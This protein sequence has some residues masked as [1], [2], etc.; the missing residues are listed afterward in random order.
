MAAARANLRGE[1]ANL[2]GQL[3]FYGYSVSHNPVRAGEVFKSELYWEPKTRLNSDYHIAVSL[4]D[5]AGHLWGQGDAVPFRGLHPMS[6][7][8]PGIVMRERHELKVNPGTPPGVYHL[9]LRVYDPATGEAL[10]GDTGD[11]SVS[12]GDIEVVRPDIPPS[13]REVRPQVVRDVSFGRRLRLLG[14]DLATRVR[15]P[16]DEIPLSTYWQA[17]GT[18]DQ[19]YRLWLRLVGADGRL[20]AEKT[21]SPT[22]ASYP[23]SRWRAWDVLQG[24]HRL[25][26]PADAPSGQATVVLSVVDAQGRPLTAHRLRWLPLGGTDIRLA[27]IEIAPRDNVVTAVPPMQRTLEARLSD[28]IELLGY[29]LKSIADPPGDVADVEIR[30]SQFV[31]Q[32]SEF[33]IELYWRTQTVVDG[34]F[35]VTVQVLSSDN[36]VIAQHDSVPAN[37]ERPTAGWLP[38]EVIADSHTLTLRPET[39]AGTYRL[40]VAMYDPTNFSRLPVSQGG[41]M[42][43]HVVL[44]TLVVR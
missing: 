24:Q 6:T 3:A 26:V 1:K 36:Q 20:L 13:P 22:S 23:T 43:D 2:G 38:G 39:P 29:N 37:W 7:W 5:D 9:A 25:I 16:G 15:R 18:L 4:T 8:E 14:F 11:P 19:D 30:D 34:N 41:E 42:R 17:L 35:K 12:L 27:T 33:E 28:K 21:L 32:G 10:A 31:I 44:G 40:I